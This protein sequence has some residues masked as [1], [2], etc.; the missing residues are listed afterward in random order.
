MFTRDPKISEIMNK[1]KDN[2][3][4]TNNNIKEHFGFVQPNYSE[5]I[6]IPKEKI[7]KNENGTSYDIPEN[8]RNKNL[9][10]EINSESMK[11]FGM[12]LSSSLHVII[13]E[14]LGELKVVEN[15]FKPIIKAYVKIYVELND[16]QV[17]FY[18]DGYTDL[19]GKFNYLALNTT[20]LNNSKKFY[21]FISEENHGAIIKECNPPKNIQ[22]SSD[23]M[24]QD[25]LLED[26][27]RFRNIQRNK[28][29]AMN[30]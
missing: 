26:V 29:R 4:N 11:L 2:D 22:R 24:R 12:Y 20:Q 7:N 6:K 18:K 19:N 14:N 9:F 5:N 21:I 3:N 27:Q 10:V 15:N 13:S 16:N 23:P 30:K 25:N 28:W 17:Q 1:D 8:Y